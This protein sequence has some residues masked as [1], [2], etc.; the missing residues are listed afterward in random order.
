MRTQRPAFAKL[1]STRPAIEAPHD[2]RTMTITVPFTHQAYTD[3]SDLKNEDFGSHPAIR[4][5]RRLA[6]TLP[7]FWASPADGVQLQAAGAC[8]TDLTSTTRDSGK[9]GHGPTLR[10]RE[11]EQSQTESQHRTPNIYQIPLYHDHRQP[12]IQER[13]TRLEVP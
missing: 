8:N 1:K 3:T 5:T 9:A 4:R 6:R 10:L 11:F 13:I 2:S 12:H 7:G